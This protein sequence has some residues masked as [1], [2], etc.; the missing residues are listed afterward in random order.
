MRL[1]QYA[2]S[3]ILAIRTVLVNKSARGAGASAHHN[4]ILCSR[5][6]LGGVISAADPLAPCEV[7][8]PVI[9]E[10]I[11]ALAR[12]SARWV[13]LD[14]VRGRASRFGSRRVHSH[15]V[16]VTPEAAKRQEI[17][18][19][20][21]DQ[22]GVNG[23]VGLGRGAG[24]AD[25]TFVGPASGVHGRASREADGRVLATEGANGVV[26]E[27]LVADLVDIGGPEI[28]GLAGVGDA[29]ATWE[30]GA[31]D[32]P[33][34]GERARGDYLHTAA[35][36]ELEIEPIAGTL[37]DAGVVGPA[38]TRAGSRLSVCVDRLSEERQHRGDEDEWL[39]HC[40]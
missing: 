3:A 11:A 10:D 28:G 18:A 32:G 40:G 5:R 34:A 17:A 20:H 33:W 9:V 39:K 27:V 4:L 1:Q 8:V 38:C 36:V 35:G 13:I 2:A 25:G 19:A 14:L 23:V 7:V 24:D 15:L 22:V 6:R 26:E 29:R 12:V 16:D 37:D 21:L 30:D 31:L